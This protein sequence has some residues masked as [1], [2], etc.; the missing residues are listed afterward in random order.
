MDTTCTGGRSRRLPKPVLVDTQLHQDAIGAFHRASIRVDREV[1]LR[2]A[3]FSRGALDLEEPFDIASLRLPRRASR[4]QRPASPWS[5]STLPSPQAFSAWSSCL[6]IRL[7]RLA[8]SYVP[9]VTSVSVDDISKIGV[10]DDVTLVAVKLAGG[11]LAAV[12]RVRIHSR[13]THGPLH[14]VSD[15]KYA[16]VTHL[17][18]LTEHCGEQLGRL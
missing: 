14:A 2:I 12:A 16:V 5:T 6:W 9:A 11:S 3:P 7:G 17:K 13:D 15:A 8:V 4:F 1:V 18:V 10:L